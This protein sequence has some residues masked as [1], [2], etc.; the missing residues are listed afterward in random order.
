MSNLLE[1]GIMVDKRI[2]IWDLE[3]YHISW[4]ADLGFVLCMGWKFLGDKTVHLESIGKYN[5]GTWM[6]DGPL[7]D[8]CARILEK[9]DM[10][11]TYN[12]SKCDIPFLQTRL[13]LGKK[14]ML[15]PIA[16]KDL[17]FTV[18]HKLKLSRNRLFDIQDAIESKSKK[19][20][21][22]LMQWLKTVVK[23]DRAALAE[24]ELH[25][26]NDVLVLEECYLKLRPLLLSHPRLHG[27]S[28][29]N[30]CGGTLIKNK[31][32]TTAAK[33]HKITLKCTACGG[34]ETRPL[35]EWRNK[36]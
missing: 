9:A 18:R 26:K 8:R 17:Y 10:W 15:P 28:V 3:F 2:I 25:C 36:T 12:G 24:I 27:Y 35:S 22:R 29:C 14:D 21:V 7:V 23:R 20:P 19:T 32:Y 30:K 33:Y 1:D 11:V 16:H 6:D 5:D 34:Y 31:L 4:G 13:L